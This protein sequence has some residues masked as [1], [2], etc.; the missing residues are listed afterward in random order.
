MYDPAGNSWDQILYAGEG[1]FIDDINIF[2][3][4]L[5]NGATAVSLAGFP[6]K[7]QIFINAGNTIKD[8]KD[9]DPYRQII[10]NPKI[11]SKLYSTSAFVRAIMQ[12]AKDK[13]IQML[14]DIRR[15]E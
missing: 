3:S 6:T 11:L 14:S 1:N 15:Y 2:D 7:V 10:E 12:N 9:G 5:L 4:I 13:P 8:L